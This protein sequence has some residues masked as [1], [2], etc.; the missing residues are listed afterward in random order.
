MKHA[1]SGKC[2]ASWREAIRFELAS[3]HIKAT[4]C[5]EDLPLGRDAIGSKWVFKA[6]AKLDGSVDRFKARLVAQ[7]FNPRA[8]VDFSETFS[9]FV[10][11]NTLRTLLSIA[12]KRNMHMH[13]ADIAC[14]FLIVDLQEDIYMRM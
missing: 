1:L 9:L 3:L 12:A 2:V 13:S 6:N 4:F 14:A 8:R 7:G 10:K 5:M 11:H